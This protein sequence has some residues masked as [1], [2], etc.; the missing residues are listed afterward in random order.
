MPAPRLA[1]VDGLVALF[2]LLSSAHH[3]TAGVAVDQL[4][5][6]V[7]VV[8][9]PGQVARHPLGTWKAGRPLRSA[10]RAGCGTSELNRTL[11][12][13]G[14]CTGHRSGQEGAARGRPGSL[15]SLPPDRGRPCHP[16]AARETTRP[17]RQPVAV[18]LEWAELPVPATDRPA[19]EAEPNDSWQQAN[20][21]VLGRDVYGTADDVDYLANTQE[22]KAGLD[23]FRFE[24]DG[25]QAGARLLPARPARPRRL[26]QPPGL[27]GRPED[28]PARALPGGQGPDGDRPRPGARAVLEAHQPDVHEGD[29]L[30]RGQ[31]EPSRLH[32]PDPGPA[33]TAVRRP[34]AG[35]RGRDALHHQRRRRLVRPGPARGEHLRPGRQHPRH[36][37][38]LHRV[39]PVELLRPRPT[40]WPTA[41]A[42]RSAP[43]PTSS[44]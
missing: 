19:I 37:H 44:T 17:V 29:V 22:G 30:P 33:R 18:R 7:T 5:G 39:P 1:L 16:D 40:S 14:P 23:W 9:A 3:V 11:D 25:R 27:R 42:I 28:G 43:S 6:T 2:A 15:R 26:R 24:V 36:R 12:R 21:L 20:P 31:R 38:P 13:R 4:S 41:P 34:Q 10:R 8:V 35:G 32:P